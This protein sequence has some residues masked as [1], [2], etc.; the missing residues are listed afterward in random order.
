MTELTLA[1]AIVTALVAVHGILCARR[2]ISVIVL[3]AVLA[4]TYITALDLLGQPKPAELS[5]IFKKDVEVLAVRLR[6]PVAIYLWVSRDSPAP[7]SLV[8][9]WSDE[10]AQRLHDLQKQAAEGRSD[11]VMMRLGVRNAGEPMFYPK[12]QP[13][14]PLKRGG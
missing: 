10:K 1:F 3:G 5:A 9:P 11:G 14:Y 12:P 6:E 8:I 7:E 4:V 2:W 13:P